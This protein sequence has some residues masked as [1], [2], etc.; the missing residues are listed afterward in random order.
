MK[1][2]VLVTSQFPFGT[3]ES[4]IGSE[5]PVLAQSFD[6]ILIISQNVK[7]K[8]TR[9]TSENTIVYRYNPSTSILGFLYLPILLL[10]NFSVITKLIEEELDFRRSSGN[11]LTIKKFTILFKK[12]I[13][14]VQLRDYI[15]ETLLKEGIK[16]SIIFYSYWLKTGAYAIAMLNYNRSIKIARAH[17]SDIY[18]EKTDTGY[19]PLLR[20]C[21][22]KLDALFFASK[23][24][25]EHFERK[26]NMDKSYFLVSFLGVNRPDLDITK[27]MKSNKFVIVSCSNMIPLKRIDLIIHALADVKSDKEIEWLHFG[28]GIL[29]NELSDIAL[30][31]LG[32]LNRLTYRF[33]GHYQNEDLLKFYSANRIDLFINTSSTEG[34]PVSIM[35]AQCFGI[36][37]IATDTGGVKEVVIEGT[38]SLL[39]VN[40]SSDDLTNLI[41]YYSGLTEEESET[42]GLNAIR[43]WESNFNATSN[44]KDFIMKVNSILASAK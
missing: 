32:S 13:K 3:G 17:G 4:F 31:I 18:E 10:V 8:K 34:I 37:V 9:V 27:T 6:R 24:G 36:P 43:N 29:K 38:G 16:E 30:K 28:D 42:I 26:I 40:F 25:K 33:M 5:Y 44:Y 14:A 20:F 12:T 41:E 22:V 21:A 2:L 11:R 7:H 15:R 35:E 1:T 23:D 19:L 39:P